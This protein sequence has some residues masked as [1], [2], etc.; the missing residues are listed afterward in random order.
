MRRPPG[1]QTEVPVADAPRRRP[2]R[3]SPN[4]RL[5]SAAAPPRRRSRRTLVKAAAAKKPPKPR[6]R[7]GVRGA[8]AQ[9][10]AAESK[11]TPRRLPRGDRVQARVTDPDCPRD[12]QG[13]GRPRR[14]SRFGGVDRSSCP[15]GRASRLFAVGAGGVRRVRRR[16]GRRGAAPSRRRRSADVEGAFEDAKEFV[17]GVEGARPRRQ[18]LGSGRAATPPRVDARP[19][20]ESFSFPVPRSTGRGA[21]RVLARGT[22]SPRTEPWRRTSCAFQH[23]GRQGCSGRR[24]RDGRF[25]RR[26]GKVSAPDVQ[27]PRADRC[28]DGSTGSTIPF[29][30]IVAQRAWRSGRR[31]PCPWP[32]PARGLVAPRLLELGE[33]RRRRVGHGEDV[34]YSTSQPTSRRIS[35]STRRQGRSFHR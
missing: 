22:T 29:E 27:K 34:A 7:D 16:D 24:G 25:G 21:R 2:R 12:V 17:A 33:R 19:D 15:R 26:P 9:A 11:L 28:N 32:L 18:H 23:R 35:A 5:S 4:A 3:A 6:R 10:A 14:E 20:A 30:T 13:D 31:A 1:P 8:R